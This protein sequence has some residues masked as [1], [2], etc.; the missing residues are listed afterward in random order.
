M[1]VKNRPC[2]HALIPPVAKVGPYAKGQCKTC[3]LWLNNSTTH[4]IWGTPPAEYLVAEVAPVQT[5]K[6]AKPAG[7]AI[8]E[9]RKGVAC[10]HLGRRVRD[11]AGRIKQVKCG[12]G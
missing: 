1:T 2:V 4:S 5:P 7:P 10:V 11:E 12:F 6:V 9:S 3:W 8:D